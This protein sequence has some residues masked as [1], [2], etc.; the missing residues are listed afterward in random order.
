MIMGKTLQDFNFKHDKGDLINALGLDSPQ[1][2][3]YTRGLLGLHYS[4]CLGSYS[5][6]IEMIRNRKDLSTDEK[7]F[8]TAVVIAHS[9]ENSASLI[10]V[11][12]SIKIMV[13]LNFGTDEEELEKQNQVVDLDK[14]SNCQ[15]ELWEVEL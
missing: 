4:N 11:A 15:P 3:R 13:A 2:V 14:I 6:T 8:L 5:E 10:K 7:I 12:E 1:M 9:K